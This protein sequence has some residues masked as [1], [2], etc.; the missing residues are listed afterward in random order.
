[1]DLEFVLSMIGTILGMVITI[2]TFIIKLSKS[3]KVRKTAEEMLVVS[4]KLCEY[5]EIAEGFKNYTGEE[6]KNFVLTK[7]N[8]YSIDNNI[9]F[10]SNYIIEKLESLIETTK[11]VNVKS[12]NKDWL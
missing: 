6:K 11:K 8:Q 4:N 3:K 2:L 1:M 5:V 7:M 10:D 12:D 9:K